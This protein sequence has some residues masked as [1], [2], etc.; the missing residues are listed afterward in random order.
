MPDCSSPTDNAPPHACRNCGV[1]HRGRFCSECGERKLDPARDHSF[2]W[3][4]E[5]LLEGLLQWDAKLP[6]TL[7]ALLVPGGLTREQLDGRR[8]RYL[9]P[10]QLYLLV[11]VVFYLCFSHA[12]AAP[13]ASLSAARANG[14]WFGNVLQFDIDGA[15]TR[16]AA[17]LNSTPAVQAQRVFDRAGQESK[18]FLGLLVPVLALGLYG[19]CWRRERRFVPHMVAATHL[20]TVFLVFDL[21]FL[22]VWRLLG[23]NG[24]TYGMFVPLVGVYAVY[25]VAALRRI[26]GYR[27]LR[28]CVCAVPW[29]G[30]FF[31]AVLVYRQIV[32]VVAACL[33]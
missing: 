29:L 25:F 3:L 30:L 24:I 10:L 31:V 15:I 6:R 7:G 19:L 18:V 11:S 13:V 8:V 21:L 5:Q 32:T 27:W 17:E 14:S 9:G 1:T 16:R 23:A 28:A 4:A 33:V 2:R 22:W 26:H 12:Y 20:F